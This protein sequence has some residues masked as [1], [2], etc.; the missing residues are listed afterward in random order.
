MENC[1][2]CGIR[3]MTNDDDCVCDSCRKEAK[4]F[5]A[6]VKEVIKVCGF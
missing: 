1:Y 2:E 4:K 5:E 6:N 3:P